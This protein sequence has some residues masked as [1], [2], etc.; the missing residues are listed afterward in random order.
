MPEFAHSEQFWVAPGTQTPEQD[1]P[2]HAKGHVLVA[3][4]PDEEQV[5][6]WV[7]EAPH[8]VAPGVQV[9]PQMPAAQT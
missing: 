1:D 2:T 6:S 8:D 7:S 3:Q 9:P 4:V 5:W